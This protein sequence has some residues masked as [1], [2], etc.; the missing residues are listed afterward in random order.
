[1]S[2][3]AQSPW[4]RYL[5]L[6]GSHSRIPIWPRLEL[7]II[8]IKPATSFA[9][10]WEAYVFSSGDTGAIPGCH[11]RPAWKSMQCGGNAS[12]TVS[13]R[14]TIPTEA[15]AVLPR[16]CYSR[17]LR[18]S[19]GTHSTHLK[20]AAGE[21]SRL[22]KPPFRNQPSTGEGHSGKLLS[23]EPAGAGAEHKPAACA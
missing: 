12:N 6:R 22:H 19:S 15:V 9:S 11:G 20:G 14:V 23:F 1:M 5:G 18:P 10:L 2:R 16:P 17:G 13:R 3:R 7:S 4:N 21:R 8:W